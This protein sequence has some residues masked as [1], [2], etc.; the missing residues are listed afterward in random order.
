MKCEPTIKA[1]TYYSDILPSGGGPVTQ[2][3]T[4]MLILIIIKP[5]DDQNSRSSR[6]EGRWTWLMKSRGKHALQTRTSLNINCTNWTPQTHIISI[7]L[8]PSPFFRT[9]KSPNRFP[10]SFNSELSEEKK[11]SL[12]HFDSY[13]FCE[14]KTKEFSESP[15]PSRGKLVRWSFCGMTWSE[16]VHMTGAPFIHENTNLKADA[17]A[18]RA[19]TRQRQPR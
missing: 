15:L 16:V 4:F 7:S 17:V 5:A 11:K 10:F 9:L 12:I 6:A 18:L 8:T 14:R 13:L 19:D 3:W 2:R 1:A